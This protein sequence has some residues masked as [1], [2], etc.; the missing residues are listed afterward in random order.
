MGRSSW[1]FVAVL[2]AALSR[3]VPALAQITLDGGE[4]QVTATS[5]ASAFQSAPALAWEPAGDYVI[6]WQQQSA[7]TGGWDILAQQFQTNAGAL[8]TALG[9]A[10]QVSGASSAFCRQSPAVATDAAGNFLIVWT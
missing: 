4:V 9:P 6:A 8:A 5:S 2:V 1:C 3:A 10:F 7:T